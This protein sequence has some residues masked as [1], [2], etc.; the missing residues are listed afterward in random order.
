M[1]SQKICDQQGDLEKRR[2]KLETS[3]FTHFK[4]YYKA[5]NKNMVLALKTD[6]MT[7]MEHNIRQRNKPMQISAQLFYDRKIRNI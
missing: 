2:L 4:L 1:E 6:T 5:I 3:H 7:P